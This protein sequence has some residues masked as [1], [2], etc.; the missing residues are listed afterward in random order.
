MVL[1]KIK[2]SESTLAGVTFSILIAIAIFTAMFLWVD[3]NAT[4]SGRTIDAMYNTSYV[5]LQNQSNQLSNTITELR[6][7]A[8]DLTEPDNTFAIAWNGLKGLLSLFKIPLQIVNIGWQSYLLLVTPLAG[9]IP[10]WLI[11]LVAIGL[12][13]FII[14]IIVSIFK[15]DSNVIR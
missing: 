11:N 15:G 5:Q 1:K 10:M 2:K 14:Y 7:T 12:I 13:A 4:E 8:D 3:L 6:D 9:I